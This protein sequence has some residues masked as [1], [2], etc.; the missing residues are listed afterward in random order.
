MVLGATAFGASNRP[1]Q[2]PFPRRHIRPARISLRVRVRRRRRRPV[3]PLTIRE[4]LVTPRNRRVRVDALTLSPD[5]Q[6][7]VAHWPRPPLTV[8]VA[9]RM[10]RR[11]PPAQLA[12]C[13]HHRPTALDLLEFVL[14]HHRFTPL[15]R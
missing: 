13:P 1:A 10:D 6:R 2:P 9:L 5:P 14:R 11:H 12:R 3:P 4:P 15:H 7:R 8:A